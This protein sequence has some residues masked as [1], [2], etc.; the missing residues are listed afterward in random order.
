MLPEWRK[1]TPGK[2]TDEELEAQRLEELEH[3]E[4]EEPR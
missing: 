1:P 3:Q 2:R 4:L